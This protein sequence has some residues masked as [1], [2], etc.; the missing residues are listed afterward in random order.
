MVNI[1]EKGED[2]Y[3]FS[4]LISSKQGDKKPYVLAT[5]TPP[6]IEVL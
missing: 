1:K 5:I 2:K 3:N 4:Y 6:I